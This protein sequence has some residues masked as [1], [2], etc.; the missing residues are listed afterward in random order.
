[1]ILRPFCVFSPF[2]LFISCKVLYNWTKAEAFLSVF[3]VV[4]LAEDVDRNFQVM[5]RS[6]HCPNV[7][8]L[9]EDVDRN[10][11]FLLAYAVTHTPS[12]SSRRTWIEIALATV[13]SSFADVVLL[14][15]DVD[16]NIVTLGVIFQKIL[17][18][19]SRR[20]WI[21]MAI[22]LK[23]ARQSLVVLLAEDVD[24]NILSARQPKHFPASSSSRRTWIEMRLPASECRSSTRR[25]P[26]GGRG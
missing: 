5:P 7:V 1:M 11:K 18:S 26:R 2:S 15:E 9:A 25:P 13:L 10:H 3:A 16:R 24:R 14:A 8:L 22:R 17:S 19:S 12:S 4:L 23:A 6:G 20:T 21:E